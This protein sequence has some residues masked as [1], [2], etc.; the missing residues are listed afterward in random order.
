MFYNKYEIKFLFV[1]PFNYVLP[2][3]MDVK[4]NLRQFIL[5]LI[6]HVLIYI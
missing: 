6:A 2:N 4:C 5:L 1:T 3:S